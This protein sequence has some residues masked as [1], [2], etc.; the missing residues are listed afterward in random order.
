MLLGR[1]IYADRLQN[2]TNG[3]GKTRGTLPPSIPALALPRCLAGRRIRVGSAYEDDGPFS[4]CHA[5]LHS[6]EKRGGG[7]GGGG[8]GRSNPIQEPCYKIFR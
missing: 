8:G 2:K 4:L 5:A 3:Q 7:G 1:S 6:R